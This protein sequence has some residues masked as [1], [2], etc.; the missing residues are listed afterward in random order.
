M[1]WSKLFIP[2][3][4][5]GANLLERAAYM[6]ELSAGEISY[7]FLGRRSLR[8]IDRIVREEL[9]AIGAQEVGV[10][11]QRMRNGYTPAL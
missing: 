8:R 7:L 6:R 5:E 4:R 3:L 11:P 10:F 1:N 9:D 2:T